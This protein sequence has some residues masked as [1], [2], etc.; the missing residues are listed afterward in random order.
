MN[1]ATVSS[2]TTTTRAGARPRRRIAPGLGFAAVAALALTGCHDS[3][4]TTGGDEPG[5]RHRSIAGAS[6]SGTATPGSR[7][8]DGGGGLDL[9]SLTVPG[10]A[11]GGSGG[12]AGAGPGGSGS[13][14]S[15]SSGGESVPTRITAEQEAVS[16]SCGVSPGEG[17]RDMEFWYVED[18]RTGEYWGCDTTITALSRYYEARP[19]AAAGSGP[20][21]VDGFRCNHVPEPD[22]Y[23]QVICVRDGNPVYSTW[24]P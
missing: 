22:G 15:G 14:G 10:T 19:R 21:T 11:T 13:G 4:A 2:A 6:P 1:A 16:T 3:T 8:P 17:G 23:V 12:T 20:I 5:G 7:T 18:P 24:L 9:S